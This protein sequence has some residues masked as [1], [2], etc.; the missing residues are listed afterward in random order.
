VV[1][2]PKGAEKRYFKFKGK[3]ILA[4]HLFIIEAQKGILQI[5]AI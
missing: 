5:I 1:Q 4:Q 2:Q 3:I